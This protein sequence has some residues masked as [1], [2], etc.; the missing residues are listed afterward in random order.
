MVSTTTKTCIAKDQQQ[1]AA[2]QLSHAHQQ[3]HDDKKLVVRLDLR[4][5]GSNG[6][7]A[8][9]PSKRQMSQRSSIRKKSLDGPIATIPTGGQTTLGA[10]SWAHAKPPQNGSF[11][12]SSAQ[13]RSIES[14]QEQ[15]QQ[16]STKVSVLDAALSPEVVKDSLPEPHTTN[17]AVT[18]TDTT[19][20]RNSTP[21]PDLRGDM[22]SEG[23]PDY[24]YTGSRSMKRSNSSGSWTDQNFKKRTRSSNQGAAKK[25][26]V[27]EEQ[28]IQESQ[29]QEGPA[30]KKKRSL[31]HMYVI[32][33]ETFWTDGVSLCCLTPTTTNG[34][35]PAH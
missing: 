10:H 25:K 9:P 7:E 14:H 20:T 23:D 1:Q 17:I 26:K 30:L 3:H 22:Q 15:P 11:T 33:R 27:E 6:V 32:I 35:M 2:N 4:K 29:H 5:L 28:R 19:A 24:V 16:P 12:D 34:T 8:R 21:D 31:K 13:D 18:M